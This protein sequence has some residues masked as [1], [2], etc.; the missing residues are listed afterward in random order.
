MSLEVELCRGSKTAEVTF[1]PHFAM[2]P[3]HV[4]SQCAFAAKTHVADT[5]G[6]WLL[7]GVGVHVFS[8]SGLMDSHKPTVITLMLG[9]TGCGGDFM[10]VELVT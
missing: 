3:T 10:L 8:E 1:N 6:I 7:L 5:T 4:V 2:F 9:A